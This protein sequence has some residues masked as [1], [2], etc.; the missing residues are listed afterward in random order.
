MPYIIGAASVNP[1]RW[2]EPENFSSDIS[3]HKEVL[4]NSVKPEYKAYLKPM[5]AR[6]MS[7]TVI[8]SIVA[9]SLALS[10]A[11]C[12]MPQA[13]IMGSGLGVV[14]DTQKFL[15][16]LI[17]DKEEYLTP[18]S[19]IQSTHNTPAATVAARLKCHAYNY[20]YINRG[21]S[22]ENAL[23]DA[24]LHIAEGKTDILVGGSDEMTR[25]YFEIT[26]K[27]GWWKQDDLLSDK[28]FESQTSG[29]LCGEGTH[30]FVLSPE[31]KS[32]S[33]SELID[34]HT[35]YGPAN[36]QQTKR[37]LD[38]FLSDNHISLSD[39]DL[40]MQGYSGDAETDSVY[41][42]LHET[43][44]AD[45]PVAAYKQLSG[46]HYTASAFALWIANALLYTQKN[47][48]FLLV[49]DRKPAKLENILIYNHYFDI[50]HSFIL[51]R[52]V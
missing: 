40:I 37:E 10:Q 21:H 36:A 17:D 30:F 35:F 14:N 25:Q 22:F 49:S 43:A 11:N 28:I 9:S 42:N 38:N 13:I 15:E 45:K 24:F 50:N 20:T 2:T 47:P 23:Q 12:K 7:K 3:T 26:R 41:H 29:A 5:E 46:E 52:K 18:T 32:G 8:N 4:I 19:F 44:F 48:D 31:K 34:L 51:V 39:I 27:A 33:Q 16:K 6:R 1:Q